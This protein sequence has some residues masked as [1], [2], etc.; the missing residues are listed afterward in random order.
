[1]VMKKRN[2]IRKMLHNKAIKLQA[3]ASVPM[4]REP[5]LFDTVYGAYTDQQRVSAGVNS[6]WQYT[7][8]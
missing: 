2:K 6:M 8:L 5:N 1:M 7:K 3:K 4:Q